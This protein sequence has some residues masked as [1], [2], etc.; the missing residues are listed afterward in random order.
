MPKIVSREDKN[1]M[2]LDKS[3]FET[4][5]LSLAAS[6][7]SL[8]KPLD[9]VIKNSDG[10]ATFIFNRPDNPDLDQVIQNFWQKTLKIEPNSFWEAIRFLKSRIYGG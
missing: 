7:V 4:S 9:S 10:K 8:G 6:I 3:L 1:Y 5:S 2:N